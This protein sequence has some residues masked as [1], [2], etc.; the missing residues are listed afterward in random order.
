[1][2]KP[3]NLV[4]GTCGFKDPACV[5][6][7]CGI[8]FMGPG[9]CSDN[10]TPCF[11]DKDCINVGKDHKCTGKSD[12]YHINQTCDQLLKSYG[13]KNVVCKDGYE[14]AVSTDSNYNGTYSLK[15]NHVQRQPC[16]FECNKST[17]PAPKP[18]ENKGSCCDNGSGYPNCETGTG[19]KK[20]GKD[21]CP[22]G[23]CIW[24]PDVDSCSAP[25]RSKGMSTG[26]KIG[27]GAGVGVVFLAII[28]AIALSK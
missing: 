6:D 4:N 13:E 3:C 18:V 8:N 17:A 14:A 27:I 15:T 12:H 19:G 22:Q 20:I 11:F 1:M 28:L 23:K 24:K 16:M 2:S 26:V 5:G 25:T 9:T 10:K 21:D 7:S